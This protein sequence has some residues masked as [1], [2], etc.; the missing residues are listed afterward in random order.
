MQE[1]RN[2]LNAAKNDPKHATKKIV[3][4]K[5]VANM[6]MGNDMSLLLPDVLA[7]MQVPVLDIKKMVYLFLINYAKLQPTMIM[8]AANSFVQ[9]VDL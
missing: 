8:M 9:V 1:F 4:K 7:C 5:I 3:L 6:T 2:E